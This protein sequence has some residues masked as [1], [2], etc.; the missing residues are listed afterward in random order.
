MVT[1]NNIGLQMLVTQTYPRFP[2]CL[3][4]ALQSEMRY[5]NLQPIEIIWSAVCELASGRNF[6]VEH[7]GTSTDQKFNSSMEFVLA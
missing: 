4:P 2:T 3:R 5:A 1:N 6:Q 7:A